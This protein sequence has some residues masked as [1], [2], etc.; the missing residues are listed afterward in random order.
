[1]LT[2]A[3][4]KNSILLL[5]FLFPIF[6]IN[7]QSL[8]QLPSASLPSS[9][10][11][12]IRYQEQEM[13]LELE[14]TP[15][16]GPNTR[17]LVDDGTGKLVE[18]NKGTESAYVGNV[19]GLPGSSVNA[20]LTKEGLMAT[21][22]RQGFETIEIQPN[23]INKDNYYIKTSEKNVTQTHHCGNPRKKGVSLFQ[24]QKIV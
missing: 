9:F 10:S 19:K 22:K 16:F 24:F 12:T 6:I 4:Q 5:L 11:T 8:D 21:I 20:V 18:I 23:P 14:K 17:F 3:P 13:I 2:Q 15:V 1:M 7:S